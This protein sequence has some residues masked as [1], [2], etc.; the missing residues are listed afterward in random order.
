MTELRLAALDADDLVIISSHVQD[1]VLGNADLLYQ[2]KHRVVALAVNRFD[3]LT[4]ATARQSTHDPAK[5][6]RRRALLRIE[7]VER[8]RVK[9]L[10][11][12]GGNTVFSLLAVS[13]E[14]SAPPGGT[15]VLAFSGGAEIR[16]DVECIEITLAD[17]GPAWSA[18]SCPAH[19]DDAAKTGW[20]EEV[21]GARDPAKDRQ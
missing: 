9:G 8:A 13:F 5:L 2:P 21:A 11:V 12:A 18:S 6:I 19:P 1:A 3:W 10:S 7:R 17:I 14:P 4:A 15:V 16:L 20:T